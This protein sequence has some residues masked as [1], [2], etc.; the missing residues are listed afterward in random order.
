MKLE[1]LVLVAVILLV[2]GVVFLRR[3]RDV[4]IAMVGAAMM[5]AF[6]YEVLGRE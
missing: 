3:K 5:L 1:V 4:G 6:V 2:A